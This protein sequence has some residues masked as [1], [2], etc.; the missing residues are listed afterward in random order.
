M[1][2][3]RTSGP[4]RIA[5]WAER[6]LWALGL[7]FLAFW[8]FHQGALRFEQARLEESFFTSSADGGESTF[9]RERDR[10]LASAGQISSPDEAAAHPDDASHASLAAAAPAGRLALEPGA[11]IALIE[12]PRVGVRAMV[13]E[14]VDHRSLKRAVG[15]VPGTSFPE[16]G[17]NTVLAAHRDTLFA[18]LRNVELG[19]LVTL[20]TEERTYT[21]RVI[22]ID[23]VSPGAV[24]VMDATPDPVLTLITCFPFDFVGPAPRRFVVRAVREGDQPKAPA[25]RAVP[26]MPITASASERVTATREGVVTPGKAT[27]RRS[28]PLDAEVLSFVSG[29]LVK[30]GAN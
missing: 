20:K 2:E 12:V 24:E 15:H 7:S 17:G 8:G 27:A 13:V 9:A 11:P 30:P 21:Y 23:V 3:R 25:V 1:R 5:L 6:S 26:S 29:S 19:D 10:L 14:G 4:H 16:M 22:S 18:G 28:R